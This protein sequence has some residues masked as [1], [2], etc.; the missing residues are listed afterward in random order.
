[1]DNFTLIGKTKEKTILEQDGSVVYNYTYKYK[2]NQTDSI[3]T[4]K[5]KKVYKPTNN[6]RG[7]IKD[8]CTVTKNDI[9]HNVKYLKK[10]QLKDI[11]ERVNLYV[12]INNNHKL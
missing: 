6:K 3:I 5:L 8:M 11:L 10:E 9:R 4:R 2:D 7:R 12:K 1:M